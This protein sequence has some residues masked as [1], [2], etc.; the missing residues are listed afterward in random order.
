MPS[1]RRLGA[2]TIIL[3]AAVAVLVLAGLLP[4]L[5]ILIRGLAG[6]EQTGL[7]YVSR[8][9]SSSHPW[10]LLLRSLTV[11]GFTTLLCIVVGLPLGI[12]LG[13]TDLPF[14][15]LLAFVFT[16]PLVIP[17]YILAVQWSRVLGR[18]GFLARVFGAYGAEAASRWF[19]SWRGG[20]LV[21]FEVLLPVVVLLVMVLLKTVNPRLEESGRLVSGWPGVLGA[22]TLPL[23]RPG[24]L[25]AAM[26][27]FLLSFGEF[28]TPMYLRY[29][30]FPVEVFTQFAAFHDFGAAA[31][32]SLPLVVVTAVVLV[33]EWRFVR[34]HTYRL[35]PL[36]GPG[37]HP[38]ISLGGARWA[39]LTATVVLCGIMVLLPFTAMIGDAF[40]GEMFQE[41]FAR[42]ADSLL[43]S[44]VYAASGATVL[45]VLGFLL[46]YLV[47]SRALPVWRGVDSVMLLLFAL[48]STVIGVGMATLWNHP[49]TGFI[50]G[51]CAVVVL[52]YVAQ[53][54]AL[55]GRISLSTLAQV[56]VA[57][58]EA[59]QVA[60]A[61]WLRRIGMV[62]T[63][64]C[65]RGI[66]G[67]WIVTYIFCLR[68]TGISM[69]VY[70]PGGD[71]LP[72]RIFTLMANGSPGL[73]AAL[74]LI[75]SI[76]SV[77]PLAAGA[78][79]LRWMRERPL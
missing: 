16:V 31:A 3:G 5:T 38:L 53:Y 39:L 17:P 26:L 52:G 42:A 36:L 6:G 14:R 2:R 27:V 73:I 12:L 70:P 8:F 74:C 56:P 44:I 25:L 9:A 76:A 45:T 1:R 7:H 13:R 43:R 10:S 71:T 30:V 50:Y 78:A 22:I 66:A 49:L 59:A 58:E 63:P 28:G 33:I 75:M 32:A 24:I 57:M 62:L 18:E 69:M 19:F 67:A 46:G 60:G 79:W 68:D 41:A 21:L 64:L 55:G 15:R 40:S 37:S 23:I 48:P 20:V 61:G 65:A 4:V 54:S 29:D 51:T 35:R 77:A 72:V 11:S 34:I 47:H